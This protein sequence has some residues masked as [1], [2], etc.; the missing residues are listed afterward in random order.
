M[1]NWAN[2]SEAELE[3]RKS[4]LLWRWLLATFWNMAIMYAFEYWYTWNLY[5]LDSNKNQ[6]MA[7]KT[8]T[9]SGK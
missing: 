9:S 5:M 2:V 4:K 3:E 7:D 8:H 1:L 6:K